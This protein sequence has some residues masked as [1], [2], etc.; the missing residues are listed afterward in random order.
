MTDDPF[1]QAGAQ[2]PS[3]R[4][5]QRDFGWLAKRIARRTTD[6]L[7]ILLL[8]ISLVSIGGKLRDWWQDA[9]G[10]GVHPK[11]A[12][13]QWLGHSLPWGVD[14]RPVA[15]DFGSNPYTVERQT[16][17]GTAAEASQTLMARCRWHSAHAEAPTTAANKNESVLLKTLAD[18]RPVANGGDWRLYRIDYP[19][20]MFVGV[21]R[22]H[23]RPQNPPD[24]SRQKPTDRVVS[25]GILFPFRDQQWTTFLF[26]PVRG[27]AEF[28]MPQFEL[29]E[30]ARQLM[31]IRSETAGAVVA[32]A[33]T[34]PLGD[35]QTHFE[36]WFAERQGVK[37]RDWTTDKQ[38]CTARFGLEQDTGSL[39]ID[40]LFS[41]TN[42]NRL[43]GVLMAT[44]QASDQQRGNP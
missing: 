40:V 27:S 34:G 9:R 41:N 7:V 25:W 22:C 44:R 6:V 20:R 4:L 43:S 10:P 14:G 32:F 33:G 3:T 30:S 26:H 5:P 29:P 18:Q 21:R 16:L 11:L 23:T 35:W 17:R 8:G 12:A 19:T 39:W 28:D 37:F 13:D 42:S 31:S 24:G 1:G 15:I 2:T 38:C 36:S